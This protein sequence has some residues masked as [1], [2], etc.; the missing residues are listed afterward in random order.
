MTT[1]LIVLGSITG[2]LALGMLYARSRSV[3]V[4]RKARKEWQY[5]TLVRESV[6]MMLLWRVLFFPYAMVFDACSGGIRSWLTSP[7][8]ERRARAK[9]LEEDADVWRR[10]QYDSSISKVEREVAEEMYRFLR[11]RAQ[12]EKL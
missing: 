7:I 5:E 9:Q 1:L 4:Y 12:E 6:S 2:Y 11:E 3:A 8:N 10:K